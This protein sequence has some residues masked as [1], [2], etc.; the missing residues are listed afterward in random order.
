MR[1][2]VFVAFA[3]F[4]LGAVI[5]PGWAYPDGRGGRH[6]KLACNGHV[7]VFDQAQSETALHS[8]SGG[9]PSALAQPRPGRQLNTIVL[10]RAVAAQDQGLY[11]WFKASQNSSV[12]RTK[13]CTLEGSGYHYRLIGVWPTAYSW[14]GLSGQGATVLEKV[15]LTYKQITFRSP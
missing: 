8:V 3:A 5:A 13:N 4:A 7:T 11:R 1:I 9:M 6:V 10:M 14:P 15:T 2:K 12:A